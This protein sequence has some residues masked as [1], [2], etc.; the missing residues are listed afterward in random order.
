MVIIMGKDDTG[1][2]LDYNSGDKREVNILE[3]YFRGEISCEY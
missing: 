2:D 1:L 3:N